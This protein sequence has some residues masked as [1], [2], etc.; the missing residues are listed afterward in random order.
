MNDAGRETGDA[1]EVAAKPLL[2]GTLGL[3]ALAVLAF[4]L[5]VV[6]AHDEQKRWVRDVFPGAW[7]WAVEGCHVWRSV[8]VESVPAL[9][10]VWVGVAALWFARRRVST[11]TG[12]STAAS[13]VFR[14]S[15][16]VGALVSLFWL[17]ALTVGLPGSCD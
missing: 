1:G 13:V 6:A 16:V 8:A 11:V 9:L 5:S 12:W 3:Y 14:L 4:G 15:V 17:L 2:V 7:E 10:L